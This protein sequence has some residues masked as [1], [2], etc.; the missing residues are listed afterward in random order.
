MRDVGGGALVRFSL[1]LLTLFA[2]QPGALAAGCRPHIE[3]NP[4]WGTIRLRT[5]DNAF[6][7]CPVSEATFEA[8]VH[9]W[10][11]GW[12]PG[13]FAPTSFSLGR[14]IDYPW[15]TVLIA[16]GALESENW[17][18]SAGR[19]RAGGVNAFVAALL[20]NEALL[21]RVNRTLSVSGYRAVGASVEKVLVDDAATVLGDPALRG[22]R[23]PFDAQVWFTLHPGSGAGTTTDIQ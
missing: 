3:E 7:D 19:P 5:H 23:V 1:V 22:R 11:S 13:A 9:A 20:S 4:A 15:L 14:A 18:A 6:L 21:A 10:A 12:L 2:A 16:R 17:D 8:T